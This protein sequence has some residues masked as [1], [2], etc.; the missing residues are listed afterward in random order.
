M[1]AVDGAPSPPDTASHSPA[2]KSEKRWA[3]M[4]Q[5]NEAYGKE[6]AW[7][8]TERNGMEWDGMEG[9]RK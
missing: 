6:T 7:R 1:I 4:R 2:P 5:K 8:C 3:E 9:S